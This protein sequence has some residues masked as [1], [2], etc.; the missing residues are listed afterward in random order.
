ME[1]LVDEKLTE[2]QKVGI[3]YN[4]AKAIY[5]T[6]RDMVLKSYPKSKIEFVGSYRRGKETLGDID[7]VACCAPSTVIYVFGCHSGMFYY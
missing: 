5:D 4:E 7:M 2:Q 1:D 6:V 3:K